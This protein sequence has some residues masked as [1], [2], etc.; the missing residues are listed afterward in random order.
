MDD[1]QELFELRL[2]LEAAVAKLAA[3]RIT[4]AE[5][6]R[7]A[8]LAD[9]PDVVMSRGRFAASSTAT[10]NSTSAWPGRPATS[11]WPAWSSGPLT[12]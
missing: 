12:R 3:T 5:L 2:V 8:G 7:L 11:A 1:V 6:D 10:G 4:P 9:P